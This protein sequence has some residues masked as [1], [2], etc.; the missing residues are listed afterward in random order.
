MRCWRWGSRALR[1]PGEKFNLVSFG[2]ARLSGDHPHTGMFTAAFA[3]ISAGRLRAFAK[4][5]RARDACLFLS[6]DAMVLMCEPSCVHGSILPCR[7]QPGLS[8]KML[9][10]STLVPYTC[11]SSCVVLVSAVRLVQWAPACL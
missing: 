1:Q 11:V 7:V 9:S 4:R 5:A 3:V 2:V 8:A 10:E 6:W